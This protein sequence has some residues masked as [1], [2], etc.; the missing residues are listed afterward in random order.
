MEEDYT[1][2]MR[3]GQ[4]TM[5]IIL[6]FVLLI[7]VT[8]LIFLQRSL[9]PDPIT[10]VTAEPGITRSCLVRVTEAA[11]AAL[12]S[13]G[14]IR[15]E[16]GGSGLFDGDLGDFVYLEYVNKE[17]LDVRHPNTYRITDTDA[18]TY[19]T[20]QPLGRSAYYG[21]CS[22]TGANA[23]DLFGVRHTCHP[24]VYETRINKSIQEQLEHSITQQVYECILRAMQDGQT[25][26]VVETPVPA[27]GAATATPIRNVVGSAEVIIQNQGIVVRWSNPPLE[28]S[29]PD[30]LHPVWIAIRESIRNETTNPK[31]SLL[32]EECGDFPHRRLSCSDCRIVNLTQRDI[33]LDADEIPPKSPAFPYNVWEYRVAGEVVARVLLENRNISVKVETEVDIDGEPVPATFYYDPGQHDSTCGFAPGA[34]PHTLGGSFDPDDVSACDF[35]T[36]YTF[37]DDPLTAQL[38]GAPDNPWNVQSPGQ[39]GFDL[40]Q[41]AQSN[42]DNIDWERIQGVNVPSDINNLEVPCLPQL[43]PNLRKPTEECPGGGEMFEPHKNELNLTR[44]CADLSNEDVLLN[45]TD[46]G[47]NTLLLNATGMHAVN[48]LTVLAPMLGPET[49]DCT[50]DPTVCEDDLLGAADPSSFQ[51]SNYGLVT[52]LVCYN[53]R[54]RLPPAPIGEVSCTCLSGNCPQGV[55]P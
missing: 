39:C 47:G 28:Y 2:A 55:P 5:F 4:I 16:E 30:P 23:L 15:Q 27:T 37:D 51:F 50:Q 13:D 7:T 48:N 52:N 53:G 25:Q 29:P 11:L 41:L 42:V 22:E 9:I 3:K 40:Q 35:E 18:N 46:R 36:F 54:Y 33:G 24:G 31:F 21:L 38:L 6:G 43:T 32:R 8:L 14:V 19:L 1:D 44:G 34:H 10:E 49:C 12:E 26:F 17:E 20:G 45:I